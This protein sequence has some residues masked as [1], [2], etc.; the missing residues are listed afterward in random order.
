MFGWEGNSQVLLVKSGSN[1]SGKS[2]YLR[3][4]GINAVLAMMVAA[5]VRATRLHLSRVAVGA[6]MR[7]SDSLQK[8]ISHFYAEIK[9]LRQVVIFHPHSRHCSYSMKSCRALT[10]M[11]GA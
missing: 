11:I 1:M 10:R 7:V 9:R 4:V 6:S 8:G 3:V 2:T 5:P